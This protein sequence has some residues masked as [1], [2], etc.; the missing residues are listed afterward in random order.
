MAPKF[1]LSSSRLVI[2]GSDRIHA[3][4]S[5]DML[6]RERILVTVQTYPT[7]S[8]VHIE[9]V[10]TGGITMDGEWRRLYPVPL[11]YLSTDQQ[12]KTY[13]VVEVDVKPGNDGRSETRQ[14]HL[15][16]LKIVG[17]VSDWQNRRDWVS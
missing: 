14:P 10:C 1:G 12:Y 2:M 15:P 3:I 9:T 11:R 5:S 13:D 7:I 8:G 16:S 17:H 6:Q 4:R